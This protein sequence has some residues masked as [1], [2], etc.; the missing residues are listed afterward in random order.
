MRRHHCE[1]RPAHLPAAEGLS[2]RTFA[3]FPG[4]TTY[5]RHSSIRPGRK[6]ENGMRQLVF[7]FLF[8]KA[9]LSPNQRGG[10]PHEIF[11][12]AFD[13]KI[14]RD[15]EAVN[16]EPLNFSHAPPD[17]KCLNF[18][19]GDAGVEFVRETRACPV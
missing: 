5:I 12:T 14:R 16:T 13:E 6:D 19:G 7:S 18:T 1:S 4:R 8:R 10:F 17:I 3:C 2:S 9:Q 15:L 11:R